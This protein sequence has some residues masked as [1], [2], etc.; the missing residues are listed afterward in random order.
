MT[1][2][3]SIV[4][5]VND[6]SI[7][8]KTRVSQLQSLL[9]QLDEN[10]LTELETSDYPIEDV[11]KK[12][13]S[14]IQ[15]ENIMVRN[16]HSPRIK[17]LIR[18]IVSL[19]ISV[20][21]DE[22]DFNNMFIKVKY[23]DLNTDLQYL[24]NDIQY[25]KFTEL[26]NKKIINAKSVPTSNPNHKE[27]TYLLNLKILQLYLISNYDFRKVNIINYLNENLNLEALDPETTGLFRSAST[28]PF[29]MYETFNRILQHDFQNNYFSIVQTMDKRRLS[30]NLLEN[31]IVKLGKYFKSINI[32]RIYQMFNLSPQEID[33]E[34]L[35][36]EMILQKKL[37]SNTKI[38]QLKNLVEFGEDASKESANKETK[39]NQHVKEIGNIINDVYLRI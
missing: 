3:E 37:S 17:E 23:N 8:D 30:I 32:Q 34:A 21:I 7:D 39:L 35:L 19:P 20:S 14:L 27:L 2:K 16:P 10:S 28:T 25:N 36:F 12:I 1:I 31:N 29:I 26:I 11:H 6:T 5:A 15:C 22:N 24:L 9:V 13:I 18:E 38:D 4:E 33:L